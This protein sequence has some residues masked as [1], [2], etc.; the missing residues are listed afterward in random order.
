M[1]VGWPGGETYF[2]AL[3]NFEQ[4]AG[5]HWVCYTDGFRGLADTTVPC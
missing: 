4:I 3:F 1:Q 5:Q 2:S